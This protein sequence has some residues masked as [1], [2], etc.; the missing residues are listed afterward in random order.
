VTVDAP[1][2]PPGPDEAEAL[3]EEARERARRRRRWYGIAV[4]LALLAGGGLYLAFGQGGGGGPAPQGGA[5][6]GG[7]GGASAAATQKVGPPPSQPR[8]PNAAVIPSAV[9]YAL[10]G[11]VVG[12]ARSG[13]EWFVVYLHISQR[14]ARKARNSGSYQARCHLAGASW[15]MALVE[16]QKLPA[17]VVADRPITHGAMCGNTLAWVRAGRF[18]DGR[19]REVA[20]MLWATAALGAQTYIYRID[21]DRF[22]LLQ[23]FYGDR[24]TIGHGTVRVGFENIGRSG[25]GP[26]EET[27]RF[28]NGRYRLVGRR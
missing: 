13:S 17:R 28:V 16:T 19:H 22:D 18:S 27:Y 21:H 1:P 3:I 10:D 15:R 2:R 7:A 6:G 26:L 8:P 25:N 23:K 5:A 24:V 9:L 4:V 20:F 11:R 12:W 14:G